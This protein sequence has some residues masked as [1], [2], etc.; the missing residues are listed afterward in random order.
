MNKTL[1]E[2]LQSRQDLSDYVFHFTKN[3]NAKNTLR[4]IIQDGEIKDINN[5]GYICFSEAP[6]TVL[7]PMFDVFRK[8]N[9]PMYAPYGIGI[10]KD[11]IYNEGGRPVIYGNQE[12]ALMLPHKLLWRFVNFAP[13]KYDFTWLREWRIPKTQINLNFN[14]CIAIVDKKKDITDMHDVFFEL[15]DI[16]IDAEPEDGGCLSFDTGYFNRKFKVVSIEEIQEINNMTK[17]Q[18]ETLLANQGEQEAHYLGSTWD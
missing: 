13:N 8:Y 17:Q 6:V 5:N 18:L 14:N 3:K 2:I 1:Y 15:D 12:E 10:K 11:F 4:E 16:D 7:P 9:D